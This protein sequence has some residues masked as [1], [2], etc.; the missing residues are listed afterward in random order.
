MGEVYLPEN[1]TALLFKGDLGGYLQTISKPLDISQRV[2]SNIE[3]AISYRH[4]TE[5]S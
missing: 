4:V 3:N 1:E 2:Q 5:S